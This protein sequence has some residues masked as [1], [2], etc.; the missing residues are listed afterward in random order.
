MDPD[1]LVLA[2]VVEPLLTR[3]AAGNVTGLFVFD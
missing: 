1:H 2:K 3:D